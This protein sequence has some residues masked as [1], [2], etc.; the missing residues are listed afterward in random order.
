MQE[1]HERVVTL[2]RAA[3]RMD[4]LATYCRDQIA[5]APEQ[6]SFRTLL[7]D[8][9]A[10]TG[11]TDEAKGVMAE[12]V[13][14]FP[15]DSGL[16]QKRVQLLE[17]LGD[18]DGASS[19][20]QR[21]IAGSPEDHELYVDYGQFLANNRRTDAARNQW[22]HVLGTRISDAAL[23][24]RLAGLFEA[25]GLVD[26]AAEA[27][28][29]AISV[30]PKLGDAYTA[31][32]SLHRA[33]NEPEKADGALD[34]MWEASKDDAGALTALAAALHNTGKIDRAPE[35]IS[36]A[37]ELQLDQT[38]L[39]EARSDLLVQAGRL[40]DALA[41]RRGA[42]DRYTN[43]IQQAEAVATL[44]SMHATAGTLGA[45]KER[46]VA[47]QATGKGDAVSLLI[48]AEAAD[49]ERKLTEVRMHIDAML[50][51][52]PGNERALQ[53]LARVQDAV[54]DI[55][56]A[57]ATYRRLIERFPARARRYYEATVDLKLR[58]NDRGG[59]IET[60]EAP[61]KL[62]PAS[63]ATQSAVAEQLVRMGEWDRALGYFGTALKLQPGRHETRLGMGKALVAT[64]RLEEALREF[65]T[66]AS[67][68]S[69][70]DR[71][72]EGLALMYDTASQLGKVEDVVDELQNR[73]ECTHA[74]HLSAARCR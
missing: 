58:F 2:Y 52:D 7:A 8:V 26:D 39:Q 14:R 66:L 1:L 6:R 40:E 47:R 50:A 56:G 31:L 38:R 60:L 34:R 42:I 36:R 28:E 19:E 41:V 70:T 33:R 24:M 62:D 49:A 30:N 59:A 15:T 44:V 48:L 55:D 35:V 16:S 74:R 9:L 71:A 73:L 63:A 27:Y 43:P 32:A 25:C 72:V 46:E 29:R 67:Q 51:L 11:K 18:I 17:K 53:K 23:A 64:G 10:T 54:S 45:L 21:A 4:E 68:R 5:R 65:R 22:R 57:T 13:E 12:A 69:D 3:N 37:C 20:F 61:A